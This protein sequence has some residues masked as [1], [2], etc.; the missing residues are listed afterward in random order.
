MPTTTTRYIMLWP[1]LRTWA[2]KANSIPA[3]PYIDGVCG[4]QLCHVQKFQV[5]L[6]N[7]L[8]AWKMFE[9]WPKYAQ[10]K[11]YFSSHCNR[12][13]HHRHPWQGGN[14][15]VPTCHA[16]FILLLN[17]QSWPAKTCTAGTTHHRHHHRSA[18][19]ISSSS[20]SLPSIIIIIRI[21]F[22]VQSQSNDKDKDNLT[23]W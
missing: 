6:E 7:H 10:Y 13:H 20:A 23:G 8:C 17:E 11:L 12:H 9:R 5:E 1:S 16:H 15:N 22:L 19:S 3:I 2:E 4:E 21:I 14:Q 18:K